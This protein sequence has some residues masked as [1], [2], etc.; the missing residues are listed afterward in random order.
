MPT[1]AE[2]LSDPDFDK[3]TDEISSLY[4]QDSFGPEFLSKL[5]ELVELARGGVLVYDAELKGLHKQEIWSATFKDVPDIMSFLQRAPQAFTSINFLEFPFD[6]PE[7]DLVFALRVA[8]RFLRSD[9]SQSLSTGGTQCST[10]GRLFC[11]SD[12]HAIIFRTP[13]GSVP[14]LKLSLD[15][16]E[17]EGIERRWLAVVAYDK[18]GKWPEKEIARCKRRMEEYRY[19]EDHNPNTNEAAPFDAFASML[20][21]FIMLYM[22]VVAREAEGFMAAIQSVEESLASDRTLSTL[23]REL[24]AISHK[25]K[26]SNLKTKF[27]FSTDAAEWAADILRSIEPKHMRRDLPGFT[28]WMQKNHPDR[29]RENIAEVRQQINDA[30][31]ERQQK[32]QE[33]L[34]HRE[35]SRAE[36]EEKFLEESIR[37]AE[38]TKRDSRTMRG[39]AWVTIAFLPATFVSSFFGMN[40]FNGI[41]GKVPFDEASHSVWLFFVVAIPISAAVLS[42][43]YIWDEKEA[44][45][46]TKRKEEDDEN[47]VESD[48]KNEKIETTIPTNI[49]GEPPLLTYQLDN[50]HAQSSS[51]EDLEFEREA[52][53]DETE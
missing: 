42:T 10:D 21:G 24:N 4:P 51:R 2:P 43:F 41:A 34:Q 19:T 23:L 9:Q 36:R 28:R 52:R 8:L 33:Q 5:A 45:K 40:F 3:F 6:S 38:E 47:L 44:K 31:A 32:R 13:S 53:K 48:D 16:I 15:E 46:D 12:K 26:D 50:V 1:M 25:I 22:D 18:A 14:F 35:D 17:S 7:Y 37:I 29:L 49:P 11:S 30:I 20:E 39:I 27:A